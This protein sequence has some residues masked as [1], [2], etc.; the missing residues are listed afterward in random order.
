MSLY[1]PV[2]KTLQDSPAVVDLVASRVYRHGAA[3][4][5][6][7]RPYV[8]W[9]VPASGIENQLS[10]LPAT[11][12][13]TIQIDC[14]AESDKQVNTL[15]LAVRNA[16]EPFAHLTGIPLDGRDLSATKLYRIALQF[17]WWHPRESLST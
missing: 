9:F 11:E 16:I 1:A 12:R 8:T 6:V 17:D 15:A 4:Q 13:Q 10:G 2:Y 3:P 5:D 14:W 7:A